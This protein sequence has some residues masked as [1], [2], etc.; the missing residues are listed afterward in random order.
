MSTPETE[1][2]QLGDDISEV[3]G[4]LQGSL[5]GGAQF[6]AYIS[7]ENNTAK[8]VSHWE[9]RLQQQDGN[10]TG[11]I[12]Y[13]DP[14]QKLQTPE[15]SGLFNVEVIADVSGIG[16]KR[17]TPQA[18]SKA[19]VGCSPNCAAM[20]GIVASPDGMSAYYWTVWDAICQP[21]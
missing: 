11:K 10:W 1:L 18:G 21:S 7:P 15:L 9:V 6:W 12:T 4:E 13:Q 2:A 19:V 3:R 8:V 16:P 5:G 17:L 20:I 14:R